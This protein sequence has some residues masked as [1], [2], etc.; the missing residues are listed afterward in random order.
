MVRISVLGVRLTGFRSR[1]FLERAP[2]FAEELGLT[3]DDAKK[4][5]KVYRGEDEVFK[6]SSLHSFGHKPFTDDHPPLNVTA[7][8]WREYARGQAGDDIV[9]DGQFI[10]VP[11][12]LMDSN[13]INKFKDG[14][15]ELSVAYECEI[16]FTPGTAPDGTQYDARQKNIKANHIAVVDAARGGAPPGWTS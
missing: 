9:R 6:A 11:M 10:R 13:V 12:V 16:D 8:N 14:K 1:L 2:P 7:D 15:A 5:K 3:G 4:I